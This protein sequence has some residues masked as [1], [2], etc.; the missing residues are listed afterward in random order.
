MGTARDL[1]EPG[2]E[3][4]DELLE[5]QLE[6]TL[7]AVTDLVSDQLATL[8]ALGGD[9]SLTS[10]GGGAGDG[11]LPGEGGD[12]EVLP[13]WQRWQIMFAVGNQEAYAKQLDH[14]GIELGVVGGSDQIDYAFNFTKQ[15]PSRRAGRPN[16]DRRLYMT[17]R[18]GRL[19]MA[20]EE[21]L[22]A[23]GIRTDKRIIMQF[24]PSAIEAKL[25]TIELAYT[26]SQNRT[27]KDV[28]KTVFEVVRRGGEYDFEVKS[29]ETH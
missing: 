5:P 22:Q 10:A 13:R 18:Y 27:I 17:W 12:S 25:A 2:E 6:E 9:A 1:V 24:L 19:K 26:E 23:A 28:S 14:F 20:D 29:Q 7:D 15:P 16:A 3:D 21:L 8:D 11:R 4:I